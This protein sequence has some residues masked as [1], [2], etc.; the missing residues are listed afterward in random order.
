MKQALKFFVA[1]CVAIVILFAVRARAFIIYTV[2][3]DLDSVLRKGDRVL[4]NRMACDGLS[5]GDLVA[6][7][8]RG[9]HVGRI[10]SLPGDTVALRGAAYDAPSACRG[11]C[12]S[13]DCRFYVVSVG[14][15]NT[16][17][18]P[19][20]MMGRASKLFHLPW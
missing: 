8:R 12:P 14:A 20:D 7:S 10:V 11:R 18:H 2:P 5:R 1:I 15:E 19:H 13:A 4:V 16:V 9:V 17:G 3:A 6:F